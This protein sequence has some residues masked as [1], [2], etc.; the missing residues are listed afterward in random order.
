MQEKLSALQDNL[1]VPQYKIIVVQ[2][3]CP[4]L[5]DTYPVLQDRIVVLQDNNLVLQD[6]FSFLQDRNRNVEDTI[7]AAQDSKVFR[8]AYEQGCHAHT[9]ISSIRSSARSRIQM[10][11]RWFAPDLFTGSH[12]HTSS[13]LIL[14]RSSVPVARS[15]C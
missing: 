12:P 1:A 14:T 3:T 10:L 7:P 9:C 15:N 6:N 8:Q 2:D 11:P 13:F 5:Q 4:V